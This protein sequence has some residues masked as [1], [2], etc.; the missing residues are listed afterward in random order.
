MGG[1]RMDKIVPSHDNLRSL[2]AELILDQAIREFREKELYREIDQALA[3]GDQAMFLLLT[4]ELRSLLSI[5]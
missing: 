1:L 5:A 3:D 4:H 2:F